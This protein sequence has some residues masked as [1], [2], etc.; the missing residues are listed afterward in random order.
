MRNFGRMLAAI[1]AM[2]MMAAPG[3]MTAQAGPAGERVEARTQT[4]QPAERQQS[5]SERAVVRR[6]IDGDPGFKYRKHG[7]PWWAIR[8]KSAGT[9]QNRRRRRERRTGRRAS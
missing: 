9:R 2:G 7:V 6:R 5:Q 4:P 8:S 3:A 1:S